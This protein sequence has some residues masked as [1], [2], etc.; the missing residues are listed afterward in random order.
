MTVSLGIHT[1]ITR[2]DTQTEREAVCISSEDEDTAEP[3]ACV[4]LLEVNDETPSKHG[5]A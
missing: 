4:R 1:D 2:N 3:T 5:D